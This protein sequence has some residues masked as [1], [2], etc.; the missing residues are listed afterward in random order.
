[1]NPTSPQLANLLRPTGY[2]FLSECQRV[3]FF[4]EYLHTFADTFS[5]R[6]SDNA[7]YGYRL[8]HLSANHD[9]DQTFNI[10]E[11]QRNE[12]RTFEMELEVFNLF[13]GSNL[14]GQRKPSVPFST[15][16]ATLVEFNLTGKAAASAA[17]KWGDN[18]YTARKETE[19]QQKIALLNHKLTELGLGTIPTYSIALAARNRQDYLS[20]LRHQPYPGEG[21]ADPFVG[22]LLPS[23]N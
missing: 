3:Q 20:E 17:P 18:T 4:G 11:F 21:S 2:S 23:D 5:H 13:K 8:G 16:E 15:V 7:P 22:I 10:R 1:M 6:D 19:W 12:A 14:G 9:A